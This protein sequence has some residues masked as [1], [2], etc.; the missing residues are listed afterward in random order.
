MAPLLDEI[1]NGRWNNSQWGRGF[2]QFNVGHLMIIVGMM[3]S[4]M[5]W[6]INYDRDFTVQKINT[7]NLVNVVAKL[8]DHVESIDSKGTRF[9]QTGVNE[10][11]AAVAR[12]DA[13]LTKLEQGDSQ[14]IPKIDKMEFNLESISEWVNE[15]KNKKK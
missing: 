11:V 6:F 12:S 2:F 13:R 14:L 8:A 5:W 1:G 7:Q 15:Q 9:S 4:F 3:G 10:G